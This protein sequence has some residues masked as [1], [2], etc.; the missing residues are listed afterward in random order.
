MFCWLNYDHSLI[1]LG[2]A[3]LL[4]I[5]VPCGG[6]LWAGLEAWLSEALGPMWRNI[7]GFIRGLVIRGFQPPVGSSALAFDDF[8]WLAILFWAELEAAVQPSDDR[9]FLR[10]CDA[11]GWQVHVDERLHGGK[12]G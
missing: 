9:T 1:Q 10:R 12:K 3:A 4:H 6:Y 8:W 2:H 7:R 11:D 5:W